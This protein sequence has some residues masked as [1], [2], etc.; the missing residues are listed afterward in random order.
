M[1]I[2][3]VLAV[4]A[5]IGI[6]ILFGNKITAAD[7]KNN[8]A[9]QSLLNLAERNGTPISQ[10]DTL[11]NLAIGI[12]NDGKRMYFAKLIDDRQIISHAD[13]FNTKTCTIAKTTRKAGGTDVIESIALVFAGRDKVT[14]AI[15][16]EFYHLDRDSLTVYGELE[17]ANKWQ[18]IVTE[19]LQQA[20]AVAV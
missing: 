7:E 2:I 1:E 5:L 12:T 17:L 14:P 3:I 10:Y 4:A 15:S 16:F 18:K 9:L 20:G 8:R 11:R 6:L 19:K 13:L